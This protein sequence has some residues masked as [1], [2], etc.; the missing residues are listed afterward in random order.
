VTKRLWITG[1]VQGVWY[2]AWTAEQAQALN[3]T[4]YVR[5]RSDGRVE[6]V[7]SGP[8]HNVQAM[9]SKCYQGPPLANVTEIQV[10]DAEDLS[11]S[12]FQTLLT[13]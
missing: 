13:K 2:R 6:A 12:D 4:G 1:R 7:L 8:D 11:A 5:N 3:L 9:I 10:E